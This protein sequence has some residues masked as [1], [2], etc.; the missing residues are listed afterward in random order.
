MDS[1]ASTG[2]I[3]S[4]P[5]GS[6]GAGTTDTATATTT[7]TATTAARS[8]TN[9]VRRSTIEDTVI[10][11][12]E[13]WLRGEPSNSTVIVELGVEFPPRR[14]AFRIPRHDQ[15]PLLRSDGREVVGFGIGFP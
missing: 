8:S 11:H 4:C 5:F 13:S 15:Q 10:A 2:G 14:A 12:E 3:I 6:T 7:L 1:V 9:T